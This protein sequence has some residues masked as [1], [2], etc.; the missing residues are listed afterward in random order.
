[1][2][3][4]EILETAGNQVSLTKLKL[5]EFPSELFD[6]PNITFLDLSNNFI[7]EIPNEIEKLIHLETLIIQKNA[8]KK[9]SPNIGK[10]T[11]LKKINFFFNQLTELPDVFQNLME[12][13][14]LELQYNPLMKIPDS[15]LCCESLT[16]LD[17]SYT[18][19]QKLPSIGYLPNLEKLNIYYTNITVL[20]EDILYCN[21][22]MSV[23]FSKPILF[24]NEFLLKNSTDFSTLLKNYQTQI[25]AKIDKLDVEYHHQIYCNKKENFDKIPLFHFFNALGLQNDI[26]YKHSLNHVCNLTQKEDFL[27]Q[28][29][30]SFSIWGTT[31]LHKEQYIDRATE[32]GLIYEEESLTKYLVIGKNING[33]LLFEQ[34]KDIKNHVFV[35]ERQF[36]L[37]LEQNED[38]FF[39]AEEKHEEIENIRSLLYSDV[40]NVELALTMLPSLGV[41]KDF[42]TDLL[43][44]QFYQNEDLQEKIDELIYLYASEILLTKIIYFKTTNMVLDPKTFIRNL[45][46]WTKDTEIDGQ[47]I[48]DFRKNKK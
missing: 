7:Q 5:Q 48:K 33:K 45:Q 8:L 18:N 44:V 12:L 13:T 35:T 31:I 9:I 3:I 20:E 22:K 29:G 32:Q 39:Y 16:S 2:N 41:P 47:K 23:S 46:Y 25:I 28:K 26:I 14:H 38:K 42:L 10:L 37:A 17:I 4:K 34:M 43:L 19:V 21:P 24:L 36:N 40:E 15:I 6:Y 30:N 11:K 1:M 27:V